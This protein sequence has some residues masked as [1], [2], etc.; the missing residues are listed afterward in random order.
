MIRLS[1]LGFKVPACS[2]LQRVFAHMTRK[3]RLFEEL[4]RTA[5]RYDMTLRRPS[6]M[7]QVSKGPQFGV[8]KAGRGF[9]RVHTVL[10][11]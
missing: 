6:T 1:D 10:G 11:S 3:S 7:R 8:E 5:W 2:G 4:A 9:C